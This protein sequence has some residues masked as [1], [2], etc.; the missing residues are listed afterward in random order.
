MRRWKTYAIWNSNGSCALIT[1]IDFLTYHME[2]LHIFK[3]F[4]K[5]T[6]VERGCIVVTEHNCIL[7][8]P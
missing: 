8:P 3:L 6:W 1:A 5:V 7:V 4:F 2:S